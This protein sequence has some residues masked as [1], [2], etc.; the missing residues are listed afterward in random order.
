[1]QSR[2]SWSVTTPTEW[3]IRSQLMS[4]LG[5]S[6][7]SLGDQGTGVS[8]CECFLPLLRWQA[9]HTVSTSW[10]H[11][12]V[13]EPF[14]SFVYLFCWP[15]YTQNLIKILPL[16]LVAQLTRLVWSSSSRL[17]KNW[18]GLSMRLHSWKT[19]TEHSTCQRFMAQSIALLYDCAAHIPKLTSPDLSNKS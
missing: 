10:N 12:F 1:M 13:L 6:V 7:A 17:T 8:E 2:R 4:G 14:S 3:T 5:L 11:C 16:W 19:T 15:I 9:R 18:Q